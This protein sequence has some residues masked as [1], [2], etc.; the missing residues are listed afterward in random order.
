MTRLVRGCY[1][2]FLVDLFPFGR[3]K[4]R[5][6]IVWLIERLRRA[7]PGIRI[8]C[9]LRDV[10]VDRKDARWQET[11][12]YLQR[13]FDTVLVHSD[14][15]FIRLD[16]TFR[17]VQEIGS[18]IVYTG[19]VVRR[20]AV[21]RQRTR[22]ARILVSMGGGVVGG[23]LAEAAV[24]IASRLPAYEFRVVLGPHTPDSV[25]SSLVAK[26]R[27]HSNVRVSRFMRNFQ[28]AL[29]TCRLSV[30]LAGYNTIMD[31]LRTRTP[32]VVFPY[33]ANRE[34]EL[35]ARRFEAA[36]LLAVG[37]DLRRRPFEALLRRELN[38]S[39]PQVLVDLDGADRTRDFLL[40]GR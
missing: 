11:I 6:E 29:S 21:T 31:L 40:E 9:S 10:M 20:Q 35:R 37:S 3:R 15:R 7:N 39:Y 12:S 33:A 2:H 1:D 32:A 8:H 36:G 28:S 27:K 24:G 34:Q 25:R 13:F 23:E 5:H 38:R 16:E 4:F 19:F 17:R 14:P 30:S 18:K 26:A 22:H